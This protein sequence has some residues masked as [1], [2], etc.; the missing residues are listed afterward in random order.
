MY[1]DKDAHNLNWLQNAYIRIQKVECTSM[2]LRAILRNKK[3]LK[4]V[5]SC[6]TV[7]LT[8]WLCFFVFLLLPH[9]LWSLQHSLLGKMHFLWIQCARTFLS[10][11][12]QND[13]PL[14][15]ISDFLYLSWRTWPHY[16][17]WHFNHY[18]KV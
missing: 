10:L 11:C 1:V 12:F 14:F 18:F 8:N 16:I 7:F 6:T 4:G 2:M 17:T 15:C 13:T 3:N 9:F 5:F